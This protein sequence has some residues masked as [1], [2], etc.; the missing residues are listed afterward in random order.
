MCFSKVLDFALNPLLGP[1]DVRVTESDFE[2]AIFSPVGAIQFYVSVFL[3]CD[4][5]LC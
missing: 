3:D 2:A 1:F 5:E 4:D